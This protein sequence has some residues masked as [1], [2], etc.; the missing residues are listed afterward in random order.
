MWIRFRF[1]VAALI[2][3]APSAQSGEFAAGSPA[4]GMAMP[5]PDPGMAT[6]PAAAPAPAQPNV[7]GTDPTGGER[8]FRALGSGFST[9]EGRLPN[10]RTGPRREHVV[11]DICIGC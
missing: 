9:A 10:Q 5:L 7:A 4:P 1:V 11:R 3:V 6:G 8:R 2:L